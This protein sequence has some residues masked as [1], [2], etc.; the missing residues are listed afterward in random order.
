VG[1]T[2]SLRF[3]YL[4]SGGK[5]LQ[6]VLANSRTGKQAAQVLDGLV[7]DEWSERSVKFETSELQAA[8]ELRMLAPAGANLLIDDVLLFEE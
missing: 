7:A 2:T 8:D 5:S 1:K 3:A 4:L 6:L